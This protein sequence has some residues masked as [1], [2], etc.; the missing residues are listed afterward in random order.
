MK[1]FDIGRAHIGGKRPLLIAGPCVVE[2]RGMLEDC[3]GFLVELAAEIGFPGAPGVLLCGIEVDAD[4][5]A[6]V[7]N[8]K[9]LACG[10]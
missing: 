9:Y 7:D 10:E 4:P 8:L 6:V 1:R 2:G 3:A 5:D